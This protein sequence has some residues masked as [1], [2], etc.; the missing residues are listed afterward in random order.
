MIL[1]AGLVST[2][3]ELAVFTRPVV[4]L[5]R[6]YTPQSFLTLSLQFRLRSNWKAGLG[7]KRQ[8]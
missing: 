2:R 8:R 6:W 3:M 7:R 4:Y 5:S 1:N